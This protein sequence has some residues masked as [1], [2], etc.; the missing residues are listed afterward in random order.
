MF[1]LV[2]FRMS[3]RPEFSEPANVLCQAGAFRTLRVG[4]D[5]AAS[6]RR[7]LRNSFTRPALSHY[8]VADFD[9]VF[10]SGCTPIGQNHQVALW[11]FVISLNTLV[12]PAPLHTIY[13]LGSIAALE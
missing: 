9:S 2:A 4:N 6:I 1:R 10:I 7:S 11:R 13:S 12:N 5:E 8:G 3:G